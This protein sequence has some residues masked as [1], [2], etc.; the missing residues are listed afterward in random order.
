MGWISSSIAYT[1][2]A[3]LLS[4]HHHVTHADT[5]TDT[6][7]DT[8]TV[9]DTDT[10]TDTITPHIQRALS[11]E[12]TTT[13]PTNWLEVP[14]NHHYD[15][16]ECNIPIVSSDISKEEFYSKYWL[17]QPLLIVPTQKYSHHHISTRK[18]WSRSRILEQYADQPIQLA[19]GHDFNHNGIASLTVP[20]YRYLNY[21]RS[22]SSSTTT[23]PP[24]YAFDRTPFLH[25]NP[26]ML[27]QYHSHDIFN[28]DSGYSASLTLAIGIS[29]TGPTHHSHNDG[30]N[31]VIYGRKTWIMYPPTYNVHVNSYKSAAYWYD[32][33]Y[34]DLT[35][36][37]DTK[38]TDQVYIC[39]QLP[40][41][42]IYVPES[43]YVYSGS[44]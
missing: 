26:T 1:F 5:N 8:L 15:T 7:T 29:G 25:N 19:R 35:T 32:H 18:L 28:I 22:S 11:Y 9:T 42:I 23:S 20:L 39:T 21:T 36:K 43:W 2:L 44:Q 10:N 6:G 4:Y 30:W 41:E 24:Y 40:G 34:A 31:E 13:D 3:Y 14:F 17:K 27:K 38:G 37:H 33:V 12:W 16:H